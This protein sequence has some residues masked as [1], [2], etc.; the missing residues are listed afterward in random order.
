MGDIELNFTPEPNEHQDELNRLALVKLQAEIEL[1]NFQKRQ[2]EADA[3]RLEQQ[4]QTERRGMDA[5]GMLAEGVGEF[6][7]FAPILEDYTSP[8][9]R[10]I[11]AWS[12]KNPGERLKITFNTPGGSVFDGLA[13]YDFLREIK[14]RG[15]HLT[16]KCLGACMSMGAILLQAGD[17]RVITPNSFFLIHE[18]QTVIEGTKSY[19]TSQ[20]E[21]QVKLQRKL[22]K[23]LLKQLAER[24]TL[25]EDEIETK[26]KRIDWLM[27]AEEALELGF[28][29]RI[30]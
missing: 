15:H 24:S 26:W 23:K 10:R 30:E 4:N 7:F 3:V 19:S 2:A 12:M 18:V 20:S 5:Y 11:N 27:E 21:D 17:E 13:M 25:T 14:N 16:T 9:I 1:I 28:V 6:T 22:Q 29:D 8:F